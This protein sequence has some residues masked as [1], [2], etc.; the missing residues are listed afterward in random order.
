MDNK[1]CTGCGLCAKK[2]PKKCIKM[3][4]NSEGFYYPVIDK[5][6]CIGC[7]LCKKKC[8]L[9]M[10]LEKNIGT[11][12]YA[13]QIKNKNVLDKCAS[14]GAFYAIATAILESSG[15]VI[16]VGR[17]KD[18]S[19]EFKFVNTKNE[20]YKVLNSKYFQCNLTNEVY[21]KMSELIKEKTILFSGTPCQVAA[22][23][24]FFQNNNNKKR[25]ITLEILCQGVPSYKAIK[26]F[27]NYYEKK[28]QSKIINHQFR[29]KNK[30]VGKNY[31]SIYEYE[32]GTKKEYIGG[33]DIL[34]LSFQRFL[35]LR[36]SCYN[37][38]FSNEK[39]VADFTCGD[40]WSFDNKK[41]NIILKN[42]VSFVRCNNNR[43]LSIF[44]TIKNCN[45]VEVDEKNTLKSN[46]P[47]H[48]SVKKPF[49]RYISYKLINLKISPVI[50]TRIGA[51]KFYVK[52]M[53]RK[54]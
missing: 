3:L 39:R 25:L 24:A 37:C 23:K 28:E 20:L 14:G 26:C 1:K 50:I 51:W 18:L 19:V 34:T 41:S 52:K 31:L 44:S 12:I 4:P 29:S 6:K 8:P 5:K 17:N 42:G 38:H 40:I 9:Y 54:K 53:I 33:N 22:V 16:G 2:C 7:N 35:F 48:T 32:N 27:Y 49:F 30:Y 47:F 46:V 15:V 36:N 13:L 43:A 45:Y 11:K 10:K 21:D